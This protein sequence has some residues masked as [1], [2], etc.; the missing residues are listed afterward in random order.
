MPYGSEVTK[1]HAF[2][3]KTVFIHENLIDALRGTYGYLTNV[4]RATIKRIQQYLQRLEVYKKM[5]LY[6]S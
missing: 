6:K 2:Y 1:Q 3:C 4:M 5:L